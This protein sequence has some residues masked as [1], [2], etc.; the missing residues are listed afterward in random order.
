MYLRVYTRSGVYV[1]NM[2][3]I[4]DVRNAV[5]RFRRAVNADAKYRSPCVHKTYII[6]Y[7]PYRFLKSDLCCAAHQFHPNGHESYTAD[8]NSFLN[9]FFYMKNDR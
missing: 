6:S 3:V 7:P 4:Q 2:S 8:H 9:G 1:Y 5:L